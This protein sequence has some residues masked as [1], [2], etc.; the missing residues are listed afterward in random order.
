MNYLPFC[1]YN[2][3]G[4]ANGDARASFASSYGLL[5][6]APVQ[7]IA[8]RIYTVIKDCLISRCKIGSWT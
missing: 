5:D 1:G 4:A 3:Y 7:L 2:F 8:R 6:S